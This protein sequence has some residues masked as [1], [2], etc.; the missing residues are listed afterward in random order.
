MFAGKSGVFKFVS[1]PSEGAELG[2]RATELVAHRLAHDQVAAGLCWTKS[3]LGKECCAD[4]PGCVVGEDEGRLRVVVGD[5]LRRLE[6][7]FRLLQLGRGHCGRAADTFEMAFA[8][9]HIDRVGAPGP[10]GNAHS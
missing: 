6:P 8:K 10:L 2:E 4:E 3:L 1:P 9:K 7:A 5:L